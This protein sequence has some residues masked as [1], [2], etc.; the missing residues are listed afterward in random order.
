MTEHTA[1]PPAPMSV[2]VIEPTD[3]LLHSE[4]VETDSTARTVGQAV[5]SVIAIVL[6]VS[7][8]A[9]VIIIV[10]AVL[11]QVLA[12]A[13]YLSWFAQFMHT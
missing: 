1:A 10:L 5:W 6:S 11:F 9:S 7:A 12:P 2:E 8:L 13:L 3:I 4:D